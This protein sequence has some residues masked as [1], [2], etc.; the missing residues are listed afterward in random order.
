MFATEDFG[1]ESHSTTR[2]AVAETIS[3]EH[4]SNGGMADNGLLLGATDGHLEHELERP[5][6]T[7]LQDMLEIGII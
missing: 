6:R 4:T 7:R 1:A 2:E 5:L 3:Y